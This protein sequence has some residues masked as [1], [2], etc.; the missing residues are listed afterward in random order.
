M[1]DPY[2][3]RREQLVPASLAETFRFFSEARNL[4][5]ITPPWLNFRV[6]SCPEELSSGAEIFYRLSWHGIP[7]RWK[8]RI[9]R[10]D[11]PYSFEDFQESGPYR[12]WQHTHTFVE[13]QDGTMM[14]DIVRY[15]LPLGPIGRLVHQAV[16]RKAVED[17]FDYRYKAVEEIFAK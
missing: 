5:T 8:T 12:L 13:R 11:M 9:T 2:I 7:L 10:W 1:S 6:L 17:I 14:T 15:E 4:E 3:L 16:V